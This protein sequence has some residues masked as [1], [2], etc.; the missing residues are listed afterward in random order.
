MVAGHSAF[1]MN[2]FSLPA[3]D[4]WYVRKTGWVRGPYSLDDMRR[5]RELGWLSR[6]ESVS[7][8]LQT[9]EPAGQFADLWQ[10]HS[11]TSA[12][13]T[14]SRPPA[15]AER[16]NRWRY[17][18]EGNPCDEPVS[19]ATLQI[20][21]SLGRLRETDLI[22]REG[23]PEWRSAEKV[24]GIIEGPS[25][26]CSA[27]GAAVSQRDSRCRCCGARLPS[28]SPP[29]SE[30][31]M[32]CGV[33]GVVLFPAFPLWMIAIAIGSRD[34]EEIAKGRMNPRGQRAARFSTRMGVLGGVLFILSAAAA[35]VGYLVRA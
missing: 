16:A 1:E 33:L 2:D 11:P 4:V 25:E 19:F 15:E 9:W 12:K 28:L 30:L 21:A 32:A 23:W 6:T 24:P 31:C 34:S 3:A 26:W 13:T 8:D 14:E 7:R 17:I 27:C 29:H 5:F 18:V 20:L 10:E 35:L 22:W